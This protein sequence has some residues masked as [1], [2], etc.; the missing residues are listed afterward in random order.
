VYVFS[1]APDC[2]AAWP[3]GPAVRPGRARGPAG[4][5]GGAFLRVALPP[6]CRSIYDAILAPVVGLPAVE[7][8]RP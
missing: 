5:E 1:S 7:R 2:G 6:G 4:V 3:R 8:H